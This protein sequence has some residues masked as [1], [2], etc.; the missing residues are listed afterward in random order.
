M[1]IIQ[2]TSYIKFSFINKNN[3]ILI[4]EET[5]EET[6]SNSMDKKATKFP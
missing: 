2:N 4:M 6:V 3:S 1:L 5:R